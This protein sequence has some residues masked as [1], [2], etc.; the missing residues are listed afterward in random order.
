MDANVHP[1]KIRVRFR[2]AAEFTSLYSTLWK[3]AIRDAPGLGAGAKPRR[4][5]LHFAWTAVICV[6]RTCSFW[7]TNRFHSMPRCLVRRLTQQ[8]PYLTTAHRFAV[9]EITHPLGFALAQLSGIYVLSQNQHGL[10]VVDMH[11]AHERIVCRKLRA[12]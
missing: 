5:P 11:A 10:V 7:P 8:P 4:R 9:S 2:D 12:R 6:N 3:S 1:T